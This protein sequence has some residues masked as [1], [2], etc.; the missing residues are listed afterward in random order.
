MANLNNLIYLL[1]FL[2]NLSYYFYIPVQEKVDLL[3]FLVNL[4][5]VIKINFF[6]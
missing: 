3:N 2:I 4:I 6:S 1:H 5:L